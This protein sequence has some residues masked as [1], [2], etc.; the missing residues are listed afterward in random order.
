MTKMH[1]VPANV[2]SIEVK[3]LSRIDHK[4][5]VGKHTRC[6]LIAGW[7]AY[8]P[9]VGT[10]YF[11]RLISSWREDCI[12]PG[13]DPC[14]MAMWADMERQH[15]W[16]PSCG[17]LLSTGTRSLV[18]AGKYWLQSTATW[19][20]KGLLLREYCQVTDHSQKPSITLQATQ[21]L[22][23]YGVLFLLEKHGPL[24]D[25]FSHRESKVTKPGSALGK[26]LYIDRKLQA[27]SHAIRQSNSHA[28]CLYMFILHTH[29]Y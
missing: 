26:A 14:R 16:Q 18:C 29:T 1:T 2:Q 19:P 5:W 3:Y 7:C 10:G 21:P 8:A 27:M 25:V 22:G 9:N 12:V 4:V 13:G 11:R 24:P 20:I 15:G 17:P 6:N 28:K 23:K